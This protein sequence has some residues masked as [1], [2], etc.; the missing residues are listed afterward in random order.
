MDQGIREPLLNQAKEHVVNTFN[1]FNTLQVQN[2]DERA[3]KGSIT[4]AMAKILENCPE[5]IPTPFSGSCFQITKDMSKFVLGNFEG[6]LAVMDIKSRK[7]IK[8]LPVTSQILTIALSEDDRFAYLGGG[9][10]LIRCYDLESFELVTS[11]EGHENEVN[12]IICKDDV[13]YSVSQDGTAREWNL[14]S[15][16]SRILLTHESPIK[17][18]SLRDD[19][20]YLGLGC[21][22]GQVLI[23]D[24]ESEEVVNLQENS[25][26]KAVWCVK[27]SPNNKYVGACG[28]S[29]EIKLW[30]FETLSL[31]KTFGGHGVA[32][33]W[34]EFTKDCSKLVSG[35]RDNAVKVWSL[36]KD[37]KEKTLEKHSNWVQQ[38]I[39][40][41]TQTSFFSLSQ[42]KKI[43][44][45]RM[46][47][48]EDQILLKEHTDYVYGIHYVKSR[49][50]LVSNSG[51]GK[52]VVWN[53]QTLDKVEELVHEGGIYAMAVTPDENYVITCPDSGRL[54][55]WSLSSFEKVQEKVS[56]GG[57]V[58]SILISNTGKYFMTGDLAYRVTMWD[59]ESFEVLKIFRDHT[60][61]VWSLAAT[62]DEKLL[63]SGGN[64]KI[65]RVYDIQQEKK[66]EDLHGHQRRVSVLKVSPHNNLL[67]SGSWDHEIRLWD[68]RSSGCIKVLKHHGGSVNAFYF[69][70]NPSPYMLSGS[71]DKSITFWNQS[72]FTLCFS[73]QI[74]D[75]CKTICLFDEENYIAIND[76]R[77]ILVL[78]NPL[79]NQEFAIYGNP[80]SEQVYL[81]YLRSVISQEEQDLEH[82][83][84]YDKWFMSPYHFNTAHFFSYLNKQT[85]MKKALKEGVPFISSPTGVS[86]F[87]LAEKRGFDEIVYMLVKELIKRGADN[88]ASFYVLE[89]MLADLNLKGFKVLPDL[90][91]SLFLHFKQKK[92]FYCSSDTNLP[93]YR[94]SDFIRPES[95]DFLNADHHKN[96][97]KP[98]DYYGLGIKLALEPG[99][100]S[101]IEFLESIKDSPNSEIFRSEFMNY[102]LDYK[103]N[104]VKSVQITQG[105]CYCF[106]LVLLCLFVVFENQH[107]FMLMLAFV[108]NAA[109]LVYEV[110]QM[111]VMGASYWADSINYIDLLRSLFCFFY[112]FMF[113]F[114]VLVDYEYSILT[115]LMFISFLR[116]ITYFRLFQNTRYM[117]NLLAE[118]IKDMQS[119]LIL[120]FYSTVAFGMIFKT[121]NPD[122]DTFATFLSKSYLLDLGEFDTDNLL[123]LDWFFFFLATVINPLIMLN[124]L[125]SIM[126]D[127]FARVQEGIE[128]ADRKELTEMI[129]E[130]EYL[131]FWKR[132]SNN[133][134]YLHLCEEDLRLDGGSKTLES[135]IK[136]LKS[137]L[138]SIDS[139]I[140]EVKNS[141]QE[142][143]SLIK[144]ED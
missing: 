137:R 6:R 60:G 93:L 47:D 24:L 30:D 79:K 81:D 102:L 55:K 56:E 96:E 103:W 108:A 66:V 16:E 58:K 29:R 65:I 3:W 14:Q 88:Y 36:E 31:Y 12:W 25:N 76:G 125:I 113:L 98:V 35:G 11:L 46:P 95:S 48:L 42:D 87:V 116:G 114:G 138:S 97:E 15:D 136:E 110:Y 4:E 52:V 74:K 141:N 77:D 117:I 68:I 112:V 5:V 128:V 75:R 33:K 94:T 91:E 57:I 133:K 78:K 28:Y 119:F 69:T 132:N 86:P 38:I 2:E 144:K 9:D 85:L 111:F 1:S 13:L 73:I 142:I 92:Q 101:S 23:Y 64:D 59:L 45:W 129:L 83:P 135:R 109:L 70:L 54:I 115:A 49:N 118:V 72:D 26:N 71:D 53:A 8:D 7:V 27:F 123:T 80:G 139:S 21:L 51:D 107:G 18:V 106:Y 89:D 40:N 82:N 126:G 127:T 20:K 62:S 99:S 124:L 84:D 90:Y 39:F 140:Q 19:G 104:Q 105:A 41:K 143:L 61:T 22:D 121:L 122:T 43:I 44:K 10:N 63:F 50:F 32:V 37:R 34:F 17:N 134:E 120:L 67:I 130:V 100:Q 131:M